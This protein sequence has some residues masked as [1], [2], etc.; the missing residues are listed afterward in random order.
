MP[1]TPC[2]QFHLAVHGLVCP[3][4]F[5]QLPLLQPLLQPHGLYLRAKYAVNSFIFHIFVSL[6]VINEVQ[7][8]VLVLLLEPDS[9]FTN[10][11]S[12]SAIDFLMVTVT[13]THKAD[14]WFSSFAGQ[15]LL[16]YFNTAETFLTLSRARPVVRRFVLRCLAIQRPLPRNRCCLAA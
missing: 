16:T 7:L 12:F 6:L 11:A 4:Q 1:Y 10:V 2:S 14:S 3:Q 15:N 9:Y 5:S 13:T 8:P